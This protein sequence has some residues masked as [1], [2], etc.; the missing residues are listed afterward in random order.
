MNIIKGLSENNQKTLLEALSLLA[1]SNDENKERTEALRAQLAGEVAPITVVQDVYDWMFRESPEDCSAEDAAPFQMTARLNADQPQFSFKR[2]GFVVADVFIE[3]NR[4]TP[5]LHINTSDGDGLMHVHFA[6]GGIVMVPDNPNVAM[7]SSSRDRHTYDCQGYL[8]RHQRDHYMLNECANQ[9]F[10]AYD[11]GCQVTDAD[12]WE[13]ENELHWFKT[14]YAEDNDANT[15]RLCF[16]VRFD[17]RY[18]EVVKEAYALD[19]ENGTV[20]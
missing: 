7:E 14:V 10:E 12:R 16:H 13:K 6:Q 9:A 11:F 20:I 3:I 1:Q 17:E 18:E 5:A 2:N 15:R 4:G 8:L 19:M